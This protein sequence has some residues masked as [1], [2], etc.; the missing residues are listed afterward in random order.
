[1]K[2]KK[3]GFNTLIVYIYDD[4]RLINIASVNH[5]RLFIQMSNRM[6]D[7]TKRYALISLITDVI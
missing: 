7:C 5:D 3:I 6:S 2:E 1:M 4:R